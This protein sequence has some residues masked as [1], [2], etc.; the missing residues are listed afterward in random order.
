M[1]LLFIHLML[2]FTIATNRVHELVMI[3]CTHIVHYYCMH[4]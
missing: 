2:L 4:E 1:Q 3:V